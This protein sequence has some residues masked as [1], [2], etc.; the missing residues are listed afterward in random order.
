LP[1]TSSPTQPPEQLSSRDLKTR[2]PQPVVRADV[3]DVLHCYRAALE[4][5]ADPPPSRRTPFGPL[6]RLVC[7]LRPAWGLQRLVVEEIRGRIDLINRRY[8][9]RLAL[10]EQD[11]HDREARDA[12]RDFASSLP[13]PRSRLFAVLPLLAVIAVSQVLLALLL[14]SQQG[15]AKNADGRL[16]PEALLK[17]LAQVGDLNPAGYGDTVSLLLHNSPKVTALALGILTLSVYVVWR[18]RLPAVR[19]KRMVFEMPGAIGSR[20]ASSEL[21]ARALQLRLR[22]KEVALFA[23]L[24]MPPPSDS[25]TDLWVKGTPAVI[26]LAL[27]A[28]TL[29]PPSQAGLAIFFLMLATV[30]LWWLAREW[31]RRPLHANLVTA[32]VQKNAQG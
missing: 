26:L 4:L 11:P 7:R 29:T 21:G 27:A 5:A 31:R 16:L 6:T 12:V 25:A 18:P 14:R 23:A 3:R 32:Q 24:R 1:T 28:L 9:L 17:Q 30:R 15:L 22:D 8:C 13:P 2:A 10:G 19:L 20:T